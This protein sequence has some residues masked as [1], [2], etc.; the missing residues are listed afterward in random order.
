MT[1][2][3]RAMRSGLAHMHPTHRAPQKPNQ[4]YSVWQTTD[5]LDGCLCKSSYWVW[6]YCCWILM[7]ACVW[8]YLERTGP[9]FF[10][11][12]GQS[13]LLKG[14]ELLNAAENQQ[15]GPNFDIE[16]DAFWVL[17]SDLMPVTMCH[18]SGCHTSGHGPP[19]HRVMCTLPSRRWLLGSW[20]QVC[21][22]GGDGGLTDHLPDCLED[23]S[24]TASQRSDGC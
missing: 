23:E 8:G 22:A 1:F 11:R 5:K 7:Y 3:A 15:K 10:S 18:H 24:K 4:S 16:R 21:S 20:S 19:L 17:C 12:K 14:R 13:E 2:V 6:F 9:T